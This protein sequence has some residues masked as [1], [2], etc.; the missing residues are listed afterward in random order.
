MPRATPGR[1]VERV[2]IL[3][4]PSFSD[5]PARNL[6]TMFAET[7]APTAFGTAQ[8]LNADRGWDLRYGHYG[9][10][11][12]F[13]GPHLRAH[14]TRH[15]LVVEYQLDPKMPMATEVRQAIANRCGVSVALKIGDARL[16]RLPFPT[17]V[18]TRARLE[19]IAL[20]EPHEKPAYASAVAMRFEGSRTSDDRQLREQI[21]AV[22]REA[23]FRNSRSKS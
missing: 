17:S 9:P 13:A 14:D 15:G 20:L 1:V 11:L 18:V 4:C 12:A 8:E 7:I 6:G 10:R 16:V 2:L 3:A 22:I 5:A 23:R 19:H 21:D